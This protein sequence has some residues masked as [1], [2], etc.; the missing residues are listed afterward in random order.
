MQ[1]ATLVTGGSDRIGREIALTLAEMGF[2][3]ALHY[4]SSVD[5]AQETSA[6]IKSKHVDCTI[7]KAN[8]NDSAEVISMFEEVT[9]QFKISILINNASVYSESSLRDN[10]LKSYDKFFNI[11][12]KAPYLLTKLFANKFKEG[13]IINI[14][15]A[16]AS[17][18]KTINFDYLLTKKALHEFT[19]M[20]AMELAPSIRVNAI[21]PGIILAP[22][23]KDDEYISR[24]AQQTPMKKVGSLQSIR[25]AVKYIV[26]SDFTT[27]QVIY[28]DG[29]MHL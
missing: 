10:N 27:G 28:V 11:N 16:K 19:M 23:G 1:T 18:N 7:Y 13:L 6:L 4:S 5:K 21:A 12:F 20:S 26:T 2:D 14:L 3:I 17:K 22:K 24:L 15:D 8:F 29:G 9:K 25:D